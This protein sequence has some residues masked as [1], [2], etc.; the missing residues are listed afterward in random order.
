MG[1]L[2][3]KLRRGGKN[4]LRSTKHTEQQLA[5]GEQKHTANAED[6]GKNHNPPSTGAA[7]GIL[8]AD[9]VAAAEDAL[10]KVLH[11]ADVVQTFSKF[12]F[13]V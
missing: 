6:G 7:R 3:S 2:K 12:R 13:R 9:D 1:I 4:A 11:A 5:A 8:T 10:D